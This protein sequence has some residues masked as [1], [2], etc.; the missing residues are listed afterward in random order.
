MGSSVYRRMARVVE[1][2]STSEIG[3]TIS[4]P[5]YRIAMEPRDR[6]QTLVA[7][8]PGGHAQFDRALRAGGRFETQPRQ[9]RVTRC[10]RAGVVQ[11]L[12]DAIAFAAVEV[13]PHDRVID[14]R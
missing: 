2:A 7:S 5:P 4:E 13:L 10:R 3:S 14:D 12:H 8:R 9:R 1:S 11:R 6:Q